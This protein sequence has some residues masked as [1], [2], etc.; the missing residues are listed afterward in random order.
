M[1]QCDY[2]RASR[3]TPKQEL[4]GHCGVSAPVCPE[5]S[6]GLRLCFTAHPIS[7]WRGAVVLGGEDGVTI[8]PP[9]ERQEES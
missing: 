3:V 6:Q 1:H 2:S 7:G 9:G 8:C 5:A 4:I